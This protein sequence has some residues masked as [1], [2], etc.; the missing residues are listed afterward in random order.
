MP[1]SSAIS[2]CVRPL[3]STRRTASCANSFVNR[4]CCLIEFLIAQKELSTFPKQVQYDIAVQRQQSLETRLQHLTANGNSEAYLKLRRLE[5]TAE[6]DRDLYQSYLSQYNDIPERSTLVGT[7]ARIISQPTVPTSPSSS[8]LK[9]YAIGGIAGFASALI[10]AFLL[11]YLRRSVK[12]GTEV[13]Q[14]FG[15]PVVGVIPFMQYRKPFDAP[16]NLLLHRMLD[17]PLSPL[18][19]AVR[20]MRI[21]LELT[22]A[23]PKVILVTS[24]LPAEG[25]STAAMLLAASSANSGKRTVLLDCDLR[26]QSS[27]DAF[28]GMGRPGLSELLS[29]TANLVDVLV[30]DSATKICVIPAGSMVPNAADLLIGQC[31]RDLIA[32]LRTKFDYIVLDASPLLPV[33][34]A[35]PLATIADKILLIVEWGQTSRKIISE[36][37]KVLRPEAH[38]IAGIVL[39]KANLRFLPGYAYPGGY[40]N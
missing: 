28:G 8:R 10:L 33:V 19:E 16:H 38:R 25:K 15:R 17:E 34:D 2:R 12:T 14:S 3:V 36:A 9:F 35:L 23:N 21:S 24:A 30:K 40:H 31:M 37:L 1:K 32:E 39:N 27:S 13:E 11:E 18:S 4:C 22:S 26:Q 20:T 7:S 6:T 5:H 29:G